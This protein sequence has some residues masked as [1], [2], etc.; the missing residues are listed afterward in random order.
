MIWRLSL[1]GGFRLERSGDVVTRLRTQKTVALLAWLALSPQREHGREEL[2]ERFWPDTELELGRASLRVALNALRKVL[3]SPPTPPGSVLVATRTHISLQPGSLTTDVAAFEAALRRK[4]STE[5]QRLYT[6]P[7]LPGFYEDWI[8]AEQERLHALREGVTEPPL[9]PPPTLPTAP[10]PVG[11]LPLTLTRFFGREQDAAQLLARLQDPTSRVVTLTGPGGTGKTRLAIET[12]RQLSL[13]GG[14]WFVPLAEIR[15]AERLPESLRDALGLPRRAT[16]APLEAVAEALGG[17]PALLVLDNLEQLQEGAAL[18]LA[19][20]LAQ[21][22]HVHLLITSRIRLGIPGEQVV[23]VKPLPLPEPSPTLEQVAQNAAVALF[24]DRARAALPEFGLTARNADRIAALCRR[25]EGVPLALEL[26]ASWA[27]Q[28]TPAQMQERFDAALEVESRRPDREAR[29]ASVRAALR[30]TWNLLPPDLQQVFATLSVFRGGFTPEAAA[31]VSGAPAALFALN[32][33]REH[34]LL[35]V[36]LSGDTARFTLLESVREFA[37]ECLAD[38]ETA[39]HRHAAWAITLAERKPA[40]TVAET[41]VERENFTA[42]QSYLEVHAPADAL[43]LAGALARPFL[44]AGLL[45]EGVRVLERVLATEPPPDAALDLALN[46]LASLYFYLSDY[47]AARHNFERRLA[48]AQA[49]GNVTGIAESQRNLGTIAVAEGNFHE[50]CAAF[51]QALTSAETQ[52]NQEVIAM[53]HTNLGVTRYALGELNTAAEH[54]R[55][56]IQVGEALGF[57]RG[58]VNCWHGLGACLIGKAPRAELQHCHQRGLDAARELGDPLL[59]ADSVLHLASSHLEAHAPQQ[60]AAYIAEAA[61]RVQGLG[62]FDMERRV[63]EYAAQ[64]AHVL[65]RPRE[66][67]LLLRAAD[68]LTADHGLS[69]LG[70]AQ[71]ERDALAAAL[72]PAMLSPEP[73]PTGDALYALI[74][75]VTE[76]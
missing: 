2:I 45:T 33:L 62:T 39:L 64:L 4:D 63:C 34:S 75:S 73:V 6:G 37:A 22:P 21:L 40:V 9:A 29:H 26:A 35:T 61:E 55:A 30:W 38:S 47:K 19:P 71:A 48:V 32:H 54:F 57:L 31:A 27:G 42:A 11:S 65:Q 18:V 16:P 3:E 49:L 25:L 76:L 72:G 36:D 50:A 46:G 12:A 15:D 51:A 68:Q 14:V 5:A 24:V 23:A 10:S 13:P 59:I 52:G 69:R 43:R 1:L 8:L 17:H 53:M 7:L 74:L 20:L 66:A 41:L 28:L 58:L 56:G 60:A 44:H 70:N 67:A